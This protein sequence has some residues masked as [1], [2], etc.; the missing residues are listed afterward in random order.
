MPN[1]D[2]MTGAAVRYHLVCLGCNRGRGHV[3]IEVQTSPSAEQIVLTCKTCGHLGTITTFN[4]DF[5][6]PSGVTASDHARG[7]AEIMQVWMADHPQPVVDALGAI[8]RR[9]ETH[10]PATFDLDPHFGV[11]V[12]VC[13]RIGC[14]DPGH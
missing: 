8:V 11:Q 13:G 5:T 1:F 6:R 7:I 2:W 10:R 4:F 3:E 14:K 9:A 12:C